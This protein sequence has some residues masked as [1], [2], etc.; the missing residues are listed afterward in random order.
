MIRVSMWTRGGRKQESIGEAHLLLPLQHGHRDGL[1]H[2][3][4]ETHEGRHDQTSRD[5]SGGGACTAAEG[6]HRVAQ[7]TEH[8]R[9]GYD[10]H[11][12]ITCYH[13]WALVRDWPS[14][15]GS[16]LLH[17]V[18]AVLTASPPWPP[19]ATGALGSSSSV[20]PIPQG[21]DVNEGGSDPM[22]VR[23]VLVWPMVPV[24]LQRGPA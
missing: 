24:L 2:Q 19:L 9:R 14:K 23:L 18:L 10:H 12:L 11:V 3:S 1:M 15:G 17:G 13:Y 16:T 21:L 4:L 7:P 5:S 6:M 22:H 8:G 20:V